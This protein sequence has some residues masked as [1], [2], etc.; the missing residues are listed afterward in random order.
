MS[1]A[2]GVLLLSAAVIWGWTFVAT[3]ILVTELNPPELLALR[4]FIGVPVI[5]VLL[6]ARRV[7]LTLTRVDVLPLVC[8]GIIL[9]VHF[10]IQITGMQTTSASNTAWIIS[11]SPLAIVLLSSVFLREPIGPGTVGGLLLASAGVV[12]LVSRGRI[13]EL[14]WLRSTGDWLVLLSALTW[15]IYTV[16]TR[17]LSRRRPALAVTFVMLLVAA[18]VGAVL[19]LGWGDLGRAR[20]LTPRGLGALLYLAIP[21]LALGQWF[22]QEGVAR[23]G[24]SRAALYL[25]LEPIATLVLAI[26]LLGEPFGV[27][28]ALGGSLVLAGVYVGQRGPTENPS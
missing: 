11:V 9:A 6:W 17:N 2:P 5:G 1:V 12:L 23:M 4:L 25:Y 8:G 28:A 27:A 19:V 3:K 15:A 21:G 16:T 26:P 13:A 14:G 20:S 10:V 22:W 18:L 7:P 24:A